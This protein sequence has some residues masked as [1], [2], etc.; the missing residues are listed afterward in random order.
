MR[1]ASFETS[2]PTKQEHEGKDSQVSLL[3]DAFESRLRLAIKTRNESM[4]KRRRKKQSCSSQKDEEFHDFYSDKENQ[5][6]DESFQVQ[7]TNDSGSNSLSSS[8]FGQRKLEIG[9]SF[10]F[11]SQSSRLFSIHQHLGRDSHEEA[12]PPMTEIVIDNRPTHPTNEEEQSFY[13][14]F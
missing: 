11:Y 9:S 10:S 5:N 4:N 7:I 12:M 1:S 8:S 14:C 13:D 2:T 3:A 6:G